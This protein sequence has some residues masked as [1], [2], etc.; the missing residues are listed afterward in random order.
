M[1]TREWSERRRAVWRWGWIAFAAG[2][3][4]CPIGSVTRCAEADGGGACETEYLSVAGFA[5]GVGYPAP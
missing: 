2:V 5:L 4:L 1:A 3:L